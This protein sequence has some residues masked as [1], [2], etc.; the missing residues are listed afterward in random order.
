MHD[1]QTQL[2]AGDVRHHCHDHRPDW[3]VP[4]FMLLASG[5]GLRQS[6]RVLDANPRSVQDK[7]QK[8]E[9]LQNHLLIFTVYSN[10]VRRRFNRDQEADTPA[11]ILGLLP[12]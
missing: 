9:R 4:L 10:Y 5:V 12:R 2:L 6:A 11:K 1:L 3:N 8:D 7:K